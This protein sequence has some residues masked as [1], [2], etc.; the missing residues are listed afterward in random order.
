MGVRRGGGGGHV[1]LGE[2]AAHSSGEHTRLV[3]LGL[4][5]AHNQLQN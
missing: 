1:Y 2:H 4:C 3:H 5:R